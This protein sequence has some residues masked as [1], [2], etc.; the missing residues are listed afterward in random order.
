VGGTG[1]DTLNG[2][3]GN[4]TLVAGNGSD[5]MTGGGGVDHFVFNAA[6]LTT[7]TDTIT[8]FSAS[9]GNVIDISNILSGHYN[10]TTSVL[11]NFVNII[12]SGS[13]SILEVDLT[14]H[15]GSSGWTH[16]ATLL[17]ETNLNEQTLL[18]HGNLIV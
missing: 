9:A 13:S 12:N 11:S 15:A 10:V 18:T 2:G 4:D 14:G 1:N 8:D 7:G 3:P 16:I 5:S 6:T 17:N